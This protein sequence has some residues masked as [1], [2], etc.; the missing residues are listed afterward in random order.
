MRAQR[1][2]TEPFR[3]AERRTIHRELAKMNGVETQALTAFGL[4]AFTPTFAMTYEIP[5]G[6]KMDVTDTALNNGDNTC[7]PGGQFPPGE[8]LP[9]ITLP[10]VAGNCQESGVGDMNLR[11][12]AT[13]DVGW[14]NGDWIF[15]AQVD[16]PTGTGDFLSTDQVRL[17]P[18]A[19]YIHDIPKWP[20]PG[21]FYA[22]MKVSDPEAVNEM[23]A[24]FLS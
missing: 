10:V 16:L 18:M 4:Y 17:A 9:P 8:G 23:P 5:L 11:F 24:D 20:G 13:S 3:A 7:G 14:F 12:M 1:D 21:A 2:S 15:G 6:Y 22:L 19:A